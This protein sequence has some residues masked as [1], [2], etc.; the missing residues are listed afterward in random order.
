M[1]RVILLQIL[2]LAGVAAAAT[3]ANL[4]GWWKFDDGIGTTAVDSAG[5]NNGTL[6]NG[7]MWIGEALSFDGTNDYVEINDSAAL[8]IT[9][10]ITIAAWV[11][12]DVPGIRHN[13][14]AKH[15]LS[16]PYNGLY[17]VIDQ[18]NLAGFGLTIGGTWKQC[19]GAPVNTGIWYHLAGTYDGT[20]MKFFV[21]G[22]FISSTPASGSLAVNSN[23]LYI[24]RAA[25]GFETGYFF[26]GAIDDVRIYNCA[27]S[28]DEI[29][30]LY[31]PTETDSNLVA[32]WKFDEDTGNAAV[33]SAGSNNGTISGATRAPG[34]TGGALQ[35]DG[36]NDYVTIPTAPELN[37]TGDI[38][39]SAWVDFYEGGLGYDWSE[40]AIVTKCVGNGA[41]N[42]PYDFRTD[43]AFEP[44]LTMIR[45]NGSMH[46]VHYSD[47][48]I[49]LNTWHHVAVRVENMVPDFYVDGVKTG[50]WSGGPE[51]T[52]PPTGNNYPVLIGARN[53]GLFF[54]GLIDDVRIYNR[55][56]STTE[57]QELA[58]VETEDTNLVGWWKFDDGN[59][60][61]AVDSA[62]GHNGTLIN[63]PTWTTG[64]IGGGLKFDGINDYV[65][66]PNNAS[67]EPGY[68]TLSAW[69][70]PD[71]LSR[72]MVLIGKSN[73]SNATAEQ[74]DL[75]IKPSGIPYSSI[76]RNSSCAIG[77]GWKGV[78]STHPL[79][80][81]Q[82]CLVTSTWDGSVFK[83]YIN[84]E[85]TDSNSNVPAGFID[86]CPGGT[87]RFGI[88]WSKDLCAFQGVM[89]DVRIYN[90]ALSAD[91]V[92]QLYAGEEVNEPVTLASLE[93]TGPDEVAEESAASYKAIAQY[94]DGTAKDVTALAEWQ[95]GPNNVADIDAGL[96]TIGEA[97]YPK[98][99]IKICA[100]YTE[101]EIDVNAQKQVSV[102]AICPDGNA[103]RF[104]GV[105]DYV[106]VNDNSTLDIASAITI[107]AWI[108]L[109][110]LNKYSFIVNKG[111]SG[112]AGANYAGNYE[113]V[114]EPPGRVEFLHQTGSGIAFSYYFSNTRP[115]TGIWHHVA[116]TLGNKQVNFYI[117]GLPDGTFAQSGT[118][119][120]LNNEP[121]R[122]GTRKDGAAYFNGSI[123]DVRIYN[124][125]LSADEIQAIMH[126]KPIGSDPNLV[127]YWD[128]DAGTGQTVADV[129]GHGNNGTLGSSTGSDT[130]DPCWVE[131]D[132]PVGR[133]TTEQVM[134]RDLL[135]ATDNKKI[136][137]ELIKDAKAKEQA[138]V[139]L[140]TELQ[141]QMNGKDKIDAWK[142]K[143]QITVAIV[144]EEAACRQIDT[145]IKRLEA[146]LDL[147]N[148]DIDPNSEPPMPW[149][150]HWKHW[151][152]SCGKKNYD[153][154]V[155][156][157]CF[158]RTP[159]LKEKQK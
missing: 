85:L 128:F 17:M 100:E 40:K 117:D 153:A 45:A 108:K 143:S 92:L 82:W 73:Y 11:K 57:I 144:Q 18:A 139:V 28:A 95:A 38:T 99:K 142:A 106:Q 7:P 79:T 98:H 125:A 133:C 2:L 102:I 114:I 115:S 23:N 157:S 58:Q 110:D 159:L 62:G 127:A 24:G 53:D 19:G 16:S 55:A 10:T 140:I 123:D 30:Q 83:L 146:A 47:K 113:F 111:P 91:E 72:D 60:T 105:N 145:T 96:L 81:G 32:W 90:R 152:W 120:I 135:G 8:H 70:R 137:N 59:G 22:N 119:G 12:R 89:D 27:L 4:V 34:H 134:L 56:L 76:K 122:I 126:I 20:Q 116:V 103:L 87:L 69:I 131:S 29:Q 68:I 148:Y 109:N 104:D 36:V 3:D 66:V 93:I 150:W 130:A 63:G 1:K 118:F 78:F 101:N 14:M 107:T 155:G 41:Y 21:D 80:I 61:T 124:R 39:I 138:S 64:Q 151:Q 15:T 67:L 65:E 26:D 74:Y 44:E 121:V 37:I 31:N 46:D 141:K 50:K 51:L 9:N 86:S 132:A 5:G 156:S 94:S 136:A 112:M 42:N 149:P 129:S 43:I 75:A 6:I 77:Q 33:D 25:L 84:G 147:L 54:K 88:W 158:G 71:I 48:H 49:S 97:L 52:S 35:F 13:V 154:P